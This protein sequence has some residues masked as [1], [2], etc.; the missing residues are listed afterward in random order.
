MSLI[1][2][3]DLATPVMILPFTNSGPCHD[4]C[5]GPCTVYSTHYCTVKDF[6]FSVYRCFRPY[7]SRAQMLQQAIWYI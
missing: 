5:H 1:S 7:R 4:L 3:I 2:E 6:T